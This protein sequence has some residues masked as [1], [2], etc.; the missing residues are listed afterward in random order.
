MN[1]RHMVDG[2]DCEVDGRVLHLS[3]PKLDDKQIT[4]AVESFR[5]MLKAEAAKPA[6]EPE[7][8][9]RVKYEAVAAENAALVKERDALTAQAAV[10]EAKPVEAKVG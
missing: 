3:N 6:P 2:I 5:A 9:Y 1:Y 4:Q 10:L 7:P 8:D